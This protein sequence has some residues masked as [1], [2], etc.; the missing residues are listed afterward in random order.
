MRER[1]GRLLDA[2]RVEKKRRARAKR[3]RRRVTRLDVYSF[4]TVFKRFVVICT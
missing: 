4:L 3:R 1:G 2:S